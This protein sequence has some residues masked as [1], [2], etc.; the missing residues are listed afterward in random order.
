MSAPRGPSVSA[1]RSFAQPAAPRSNFSAAPR[2]RS[3]AVAP[4]SRSYSTQAP[5]S[6]N[7]AYKSSRHHR[8]HR[9]FRGPVVTFG[10]PYYYYNDYAYA[11]DDDCYELRP[12]A[13]R[14]GIQYRRVYVCGDYD[15]DY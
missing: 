10:A 4:S 2:S 6:R 13:T 7:Y 11:Y 15:Y 14:Y 9:H 1:P 12:V 3:Y 5:S 8:H